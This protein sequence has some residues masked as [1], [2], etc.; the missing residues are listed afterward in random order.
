M[1]VFLS[2]HS[3]AARAYIYIYISLSYGTDG[4]PPLI[5]EEDDGFDF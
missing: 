4:P 1:H 2:N 5:K 3:R